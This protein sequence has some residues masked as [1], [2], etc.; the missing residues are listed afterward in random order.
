[1]GLT[2]V[3]VGGAA[4]ELAPFSL[5]EH[6]DAGDETVVVHGAGGR[7]GAALASAGIQ[8]RFV[9]GRRVTPPEAMPHV[10]AAFLAE[11]RRL[12]RSI[13]PAAAGVLGDELGLEAEPL[14][15]LGAVGIARALAPPRLR[16]LLREGRI[17]VIASLARGPLN[18][19]AD[20]TAAALARALHAD[21]LVF[22]SDVDG[23]VVAGAVA[24]RLAGDDV[25][26]ALDRGE[27][28]G[29]IVP[30]LEAALAAARDGIATRVGATEVYA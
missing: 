9:G 24:P 5:E 1:M 2:V 20:D 3:K 8:S 11:N 4:L 12:C 28:T 27:L 13:G 30:K 29:G 15:E 19:N 23:V 7:I 14:P 21:R 10:R 17:P 18:V 16:Q 25:A 6:V 26:A 22:V